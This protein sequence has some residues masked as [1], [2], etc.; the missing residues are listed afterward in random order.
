MQKLVSFQK[1]TGCMACIDS[2]PKSALDY[3]LNSEGF[4]SIVLNEELCIDCGICKKNCPVLVRFP[5]KKIQDSTP[6]TAWSPKDEIR[7]KSASGGAFAECALAVLAGGGV[8]IGAA[9]NKKQVEH[10]AIDR[11]A[12]LHKLQNS[13]Y[14]QSNTR[15]IFNTTKE[16]LKKGRTVFFSGT[17]CQIAGLK[18]SI[19]KVDYP[20]RLI[21]GQVVCHGI[22]SGKIV[23]L[24]ENIKKVEIKEIKFFR[25]KLYGWKNSHIFSYSKS[26]GETIVL[27]SKENLFSKMYYANLLFRPSCYN[28]QFCSI[29]GYADIS[30][31]DYWG[32]KS[33]PQEHY[34]GL[35]LIIV[36]S[37]EGQELVHS[38]GLI[39]EQADWKEALS[40]NPRI[41]NGFNWLYYH[42]A[43]KL[44]KFHLNF[45]SLRHTE[46]IF[47]NSPRVFD[48]LLY[49]Y[50]IVNKFLHILNNLTNR[51]AL[52]RE[53]QNAKL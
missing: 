25:T 50:R 14:I 3:A 45:I 18:V 7:L 8:V 40:S 15:G 28:C 22:P 42:P 13:K 1:C 20:G 9:M 35:S 37:K 16:I 5:K 43:R 27:Q 29:K 21:T 17:P 34:K 30:F 6:Y 12:D 51:R 24:F 46:A 32:N 39:T 36:H 48:L 11:T 33:H 41:F 19:G 23:Q 47:S 44:L 53:L 38:S 10:I 26:T 52:R 4:Y 49:P 31:A 2:C